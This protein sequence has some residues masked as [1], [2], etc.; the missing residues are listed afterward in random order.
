MK[1]RDLERQLTEL[2]WF[3]KRE[4]SSHELWTNGKGDS[5][6]V[7]RHTEIKEFTAEGILKFARKNPGTK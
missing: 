2:G 4:G 6:P 1:K 7:P 5:Q 3:K